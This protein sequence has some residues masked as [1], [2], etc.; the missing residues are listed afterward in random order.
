[1]RARATYSFHDG[2]FTDFL[3]DFDGTN[4]QLAGKRF[5]MSARQL[6]SAGLIVAP[7]R[8]LVGSVILKHT[9]DRYLNKRNT[10]LAA[11]FTTL[12]CG[13]GYR[14]NDWEL[15][16]DGRNLTDRRDPISES[17]LGEAQYYRMPSRRIDVTLGLRF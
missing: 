10:A 9:G 3:Q 16:I 12:D 15:R 13:A 11:P 14:L 7:D 2:R 5:E 1:V 6:F 8:G 4:T 17:E